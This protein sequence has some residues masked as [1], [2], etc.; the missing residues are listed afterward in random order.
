MRMSTHHLE[1]KYEI[2]RSYLKGHHHQGFAVGGLFGLTI[3]IFSNAHPVIA[4]II[5]VSSFFWIE[6]LEEFQA[7]GLGK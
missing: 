7:R 2:T 5:A 3:A 1:K 6:R 4:A